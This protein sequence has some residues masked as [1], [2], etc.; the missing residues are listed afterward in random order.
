MRVGRLASV[1]IQVLLLFILLI[2]YFLSYG[3]TQN[4]LYSSWILIVVAISV[5]FFVIKKEKI[6]EIRGQYVRIVT[7]FVLGYLIVYFQL[8]VDYIFGNFDESHTR[9]WV[10]RRIVPQ[11]LT[12]SAIGLVAFFIG[13]LFCGYLP[14]D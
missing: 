11:A 13:Y 12:L 9:F 1:N 14:E 6:N 3:V 4:Q 5:I 10:N 8:H 7:V 2:S